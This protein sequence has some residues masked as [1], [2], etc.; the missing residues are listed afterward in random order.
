MLN[1]KTI[2]ITVNHLDD[3]NTTY[4]FRPNDI[5]KLKK[6]HNNCYD[7]E[8]ITAYSKH[9][10]KCGYVANSVGTV[11]RGTYSAGRAYD[12]FE[13]EIYCV[14]RFIIEDFMICELIDEDA[15]EYDVAEIEN[16]VFAK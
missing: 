9:N 15:E 3:F 13:E 14:V 4:T 6:D 5:L 16:R 8:A 10:Y 2:Y 12:Q 11:A 1:N 7:D